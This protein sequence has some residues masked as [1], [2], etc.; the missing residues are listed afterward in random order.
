MSV[1]PPTWLEGLLGTLILSLLVAI[2]IRWVRLPYT[3]A[4]VIVGLVLGWLGES[5]FS[6][7]EPDGGLLSAELIL[8]ILLPPLPQRGQDRFRLH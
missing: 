3:I 8:F 5:I 7:L 6:G 4:L 2:A 1:I